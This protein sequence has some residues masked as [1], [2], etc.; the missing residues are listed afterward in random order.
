MQIYNVDDSSEDSSSNNLH[1]DSPELPKQRKRENSFEDTHKD[2]AVGND[3]KLETF[4]TI[5]L[6]QWVLFIGV[7]LLFMIVI[8]S[9]DIFSKEIDFKKYYALQ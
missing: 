6:E 1:A 2:I 3:D 4:H 9:T 7:F 8:L 5:K